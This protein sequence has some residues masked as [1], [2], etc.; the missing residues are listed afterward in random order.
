MKLTPE[1]VCRS[2]TEQ[3][4]DY[5]TTLCRLHKPCNPTRGCSKE[6]KYLVIDF[7]RVE[8][9][10]H[11]RKKVP[12]KPSVDAL[13]CDSQCLYFIEIKGW[14]Q[15]LLKQKKLSL[16]KIQKQVGR[17]DLQGKL[18]DSIF[19]CE[20]IAQ[21][22]KLL[23]YVSVVYVLVTDIDTH[24]DGLQA[25]NQQLNWLAQT[26]SSWETVCNELLGQK[27]HAVENIRTKYISCR[28]FDA[29]FS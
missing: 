4:S 18:I 14:K 25:L 16:N 9:D 28:V 15:F 12:S 13:A 6:Q 19:L 21:T 10:W 24:E 22:K 8:A 23:D 5:L 27:L 11:K 2:I 3:G 7:D 20:E 17:Y 29:L 26:S 1:Y